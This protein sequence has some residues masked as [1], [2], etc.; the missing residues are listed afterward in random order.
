MLKVEQ[1]PIERLIPYTRNP[2]KNDDQVDKMCAAIREFGFRIPV[3]A[4]SDGTVVDGHLRLKAARQLGLKHVPVALADELSDDQV[5]AFRILANQS[6]NWADWDIS[7]LAGELQELD[8]SGFDLTLTGLMQAEI[9][10]VLDSVDIN[11]SGEKSKSFTA[12]EFGAGATRSKLTL[13]PDVVEIFESAI[14]KTGERNRAEAVR[15][16]CEAY[17]E[18]KIMPG[19]LSKWQCGRVCLIR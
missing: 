12:E 4:K 15:K 17:I 13:P 3:V 5:K 6:A 1:W 2:R 18:K 9:D 19:N 8:N 7:L 11:F 16:I 14:A 10:D